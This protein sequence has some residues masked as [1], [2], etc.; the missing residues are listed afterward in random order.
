MC[1]PTFQSINLILSIKRSFTGKLSSTS[2]SKRRQHFPKPHRRMRR[3]TNNNNNKFN[4]V[5]G[6]DIDEEDFIKIFK[7]RPRIVRKNHVLQQGSQGAKKWNMKMYKK[8]NNVEHYHNAD[9]N[10]SAVLKR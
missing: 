2:T 4:L 1:F 3:S 5:D 7:R 10:V 6:D 8:R 9:D